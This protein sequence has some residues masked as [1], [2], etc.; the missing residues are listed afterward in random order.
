MTSFISFQ[1]RPEAMATRIPLSR[2]A[3]IASMASS[4][5]ALASFT[6]VPSTSDVINRMG[7]I[8]SEAYIFFICNVSVEAIHPPSIP[9][10]PSI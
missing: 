1:A 2:A 8:P 10:I 4:G 5:I 6:K 7:L 3:R 9:S